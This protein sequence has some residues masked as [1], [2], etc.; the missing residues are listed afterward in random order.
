[1][2]IVCGCIVLS[3]FVDYHGCCPMTYRSVG[4]YIGEPLV[5]FILQDRKDVYWC[6]W[7]YIE[8]ENVQYMVTFNALLCWLVLKNAET[9][10]TVW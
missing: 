6:N 3:A 10:D 1:M 2:P 8:P 4:Q 9:L 7:K 5:Q